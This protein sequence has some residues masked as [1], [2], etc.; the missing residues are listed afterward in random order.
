MA[1][2]KDGNMHIAVDGKTQDKDLAYMGAYNGTQINFHT[3]K[4]MLCE[5]HGWKDKKIKGFIVNQEGY[6]TVVFDND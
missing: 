1:F 6:I 5:Q 2:H 3:I 4:R